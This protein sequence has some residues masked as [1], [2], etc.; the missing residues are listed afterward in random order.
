V[1]APIFDGSGMKTKVAE[2]LMHGKKVVGTPEAFS[3]YEKVA[4][5]AGW[6]CSSP[7]EFVTAINAACSTITLSFDPELRL[8]YEEYFSLSAATARLA[9]ALGEARDS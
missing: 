7:T 5:R 2:A 8:L 9:F 6:C 3:G 4:E 1:I